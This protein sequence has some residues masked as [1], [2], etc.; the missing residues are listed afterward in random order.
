MRRILI[1]SAVVWGVLLISPHARAKRTT[2]TEDG[3][4][5]ATVVSVKKHVSA[6][7]YA[8]DNPTDAALQ[9][10]DYSYDI[11]IRLNCNVYV[12]RFESA[13]RYLP[14]VFSPD[15]EVDVRLRKHVMFVIL[16]FSDEEVM[17]GI[18][19]HRRVKDEV[20]AGTSSKAAG[21]ISNHSLTQ[22]KFK[23]GLV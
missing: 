23:G 18:V 14:S 17:M 8:G 6:S 12:G 21:Q 2:A 20:C 15:H 5:V 16:P 19:N 11:G 22:S 10:R 4:Q 1:L 9:A 13:I 3:Y 7:N